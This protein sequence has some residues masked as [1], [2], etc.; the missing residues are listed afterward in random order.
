[1]PYIENVGRKFARIMDSGSQSVLQ[2]KLLLHLALNSYD[3]YFIQ[4]FVLQRPNSYNLLL[5]HTLVFL[6]QCLYY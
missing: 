5:V 2:V 6:Y 4:K 3:A 1:M